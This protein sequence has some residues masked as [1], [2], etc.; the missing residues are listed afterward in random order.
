MLVQCDWRRDIPRTTGQSRLWWHRAC[1]RYRLRFHLRGHAD[2][3]PRPMSCRLP[4]GGRV[5]A[6]A[7][8]VSSTCSSVFQAVV[9]SARADTGDTASRG[10]SRALHGSFRS[11]ESQASR[12]C[13]GGEHNSDRG[14]QWVL[15]QAGVSPRQGVHSA[16]HACTLLPSQSTSRALHSATA[17]ST[18]TLHHVDVLASN[19]M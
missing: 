19:C 4:S 15:Q 2:A 11:N 14:L 18:M 17:S 1:A 8:Q 13:R 10:S 7:E 12:L 3:F 9:L 6:R 16:T 5:G